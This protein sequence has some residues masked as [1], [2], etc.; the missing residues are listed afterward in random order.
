MSK[1]VKLTYDQV[2]IPDFKI[3]PKDLKDEIPPVNFFDLSSH[4]RAKEAI[5]FGLKMRSF[6]SNVFVVAGDQ[7][8]RVRATMQY[9]K[10]YVKT[11]PPAQDWVYLN[12]F[13]VS[14]RPIPFSLPSGMGCRLRAMMEELIDSIQVVF[15]KTLTSGSY[16]SKVNAMT[17]AL[18]AKVHRD[19]GKLQEFATTKGLRIESGPEEF[20]ILSIDNLD[21]ESLQDS[22]PRSGSAQEGGS[23]QTLKAVPQKLYTQ[24][25]I[26]YIRGK[27][28]H[29]TSAAHI[30]GRELNRKINELKKKEAHHVLKPLIKPI[31]TEFGEYLGEWLDELNHDILETI[32]A[33]L[34]EQHEGEANEYIHR[35][36]A[37]NVLVDNHCS[38]HARVIIDP[39]PT[40]ESLFGSIKYKSAMNGYHTDFSM[41]RA[42][43]IHLANGG[44][45]VLRAD[46]LAT[47]PE[48]W[49]ALKVALRDRM[50]NIEERHREAAIPML[51]APDPQPIPMDLQIFIIGA[52]HWYYNFFFND[53][54]F[55]TYFKIK[56]DIEPEMPITAENVSVYT[57]LIRHFAN[58]AGGTPFDIDSK[59]VQYIL[60]YGCRWLGNRKL[61]SSKIELVSNLVKEAKQVA[62]E[63]G[64]EKIMIEHVKLSMDGR[65]FRNSV[66]ED[67][68]HR[69][70]KDDVVLINTRGKA[71]GIVNGLTVL[72]TGDH[73][74]GLPNRITARTFV[75]DAGVINIERLTEMGGPIQQKGA[76]ILD[77]F[78]QGLFAQTHPVSCSCSLTFEQSYGGIEGDS[79]SLAELIAILSSLSGVPIRQDIAI[80]GSINQFGA[81]QAVAG[82]NHKVEGFYRVCQIKGLSGK[83]GVIIPLSNRDHIILRDDISEVIREEKFHVWAIQSVEDAIELLMETPAGRCNKKGEHPEGTVYNLVAKQLER[84]DELLFRSKKR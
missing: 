54:D 43:N 1:I 33:F 40:Y 5:L 36:Y 62:Q 82:I 69:S 34:E 72:S 38:E 14:H 4:K 17:A 78:I 58:R 15:Q 37:V 10:D 26:Q 9:L 53:P 20:T 35:R 7:R 44:I 80:T 22:A 24:E 39:S 75:G 70:I 31:V 64:D 12:N 74:Y 81:V 57:R 23:V 11:L 68:S 51:D 19:I 29:I 13:E 30:K 41:I 77:G 55:R 47:D 83:Q 8:G 46:N 42:G 50:I 66:L 61:L 25:D 63:H 79:A 49:S 76:M 32:D 73:D 59:A 56:A 67:R 27:L 18:E 84:Y 3:N 28:S 2:R 6:R 71:V 16:V 60:G 52:P 21:P 65:R 48:L 45:L